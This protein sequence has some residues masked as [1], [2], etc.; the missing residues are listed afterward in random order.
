[1]SR[2]AKS[3]KHLPRPKWAKLATNP[4]TGEAW[5]K[6]PPDPHARNSLASV[7]LGTN[8]LTET[9]HR[10]VEIQIRTR[11]PQPDIAQEFAKLGFTAFN[12][13]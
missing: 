4:Y 6:L 11:N 1:M 8:V 10:W 9:G 12:Q 7:T 13:L 3:L 5:E 2:P